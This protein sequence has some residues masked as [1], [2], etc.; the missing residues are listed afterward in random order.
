MASHPPDTFARSPG[1]TWRHASD[2]PQ[3]R[4]LAA[5]IADAHAA[6]AVLAPRAPLLTDQPVE[7]PGEPHPILL[8][9]PR[10]AI[11][12]VCAPPTRLLVDLC[13]SG[14]RLG[15]PIPAPTRDPAME[16]AVRMRTVA[17][18]V[19]AFSPSR[20]ASRWGRNLTRGASSMLSRLRAAGAAT[21]G[22]GEGEGEGEAGAPGE[23][24]A[25]NLEAQ[26][27]ALETGGEIGSGGASAPGPASPGFGAAPPGAA[28]ASRPVSVSLGSPTRG[29]AL[30]AADLKLTPARTLAGAI[31]APSLVPLE[32]VGGGSG[33]AAGAAEGTPDQPAWRNRAFASSRI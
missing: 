13:D 15:V 20:S 1:S 32:H 2:P 18:V 25:G 21:G 26:H 22:E 8:R 16:H 28:S 3:A 24:A 4:R 6:W 10:D 14:E 17:H 27:V 33:K 19:S 30:R 31:H 23:A 5:V 11:G 29:A 9:M 12:G 7:A